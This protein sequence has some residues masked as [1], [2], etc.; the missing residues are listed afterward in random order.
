[1]FDY[2]SLKLFHIACV[3]ASIAGFSLRGALMLAG[4]SLLWRRWVRTVPHFVDTALLVSGLWLASLIGQYPGTAPWLTAKLL[5]LL[6]YI[7][8]GFVA[9]RL[10]RT[11]R[12]R[13]AALLG[14]FACYGYMVGVALSK[15]PWS[16]G[17][18]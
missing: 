2:A 12:I 10:G 17:A 18:V 5:A 16:W 13:I 6:A 11:R 3:I 4:S 8:F 14:A 7:G 15:S 9:L 1:M